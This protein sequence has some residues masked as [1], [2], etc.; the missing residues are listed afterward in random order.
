MNQAC[1]ALDVV[2]K[3]VVSDGARPNNVMTVQI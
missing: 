1:L 3:V 2:Q